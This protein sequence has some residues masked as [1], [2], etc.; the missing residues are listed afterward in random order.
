MEVH[1]WIDGW[2]NGLTYGWV[3]WWMSEYMGG[4]WVNGS[5]ENKG[6]GTFAGK[7]IRNHNGH[8][9]ASILLLRRRRLEGRGDLPP[10]KE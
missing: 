2:M 6:N 5:K 4:R 8:L 1:S 7:G 3:D 9:A 10:R